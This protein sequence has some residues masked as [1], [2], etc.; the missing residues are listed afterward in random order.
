MPSE[1]SPPSGP[2]AADPEVELV[3]RAASGDGEAFTV[4]MRR[5]N[6]L[7]FRTARS[8]LQNDADAEDAVQEAYLRAWRALGR[9]RAES[10]LSTWL[11][12]IVVNEALGRRRSAGPLTTPLESVMDSPDPRIRVALADPPEDGP[13]ASV[14]R[15]EV[16]EQ[17]EAEID[18]L[19]EGFRTVFVLRAVEEMS[20]EEIAETL[21]IPAATVRTRYFRA[22][23][24]LRATLE[25]ATPAPLRSAYAF[26]GERC[27]RIVAR[28]LARARAEG[29]AVGSGTGVPEAP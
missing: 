3:A 9:Y 22:R 24:L 19:P 2:P 7:L 15:R 4:L 12:R 16:R 20:V 23:N 10:R 28:V 17:L 27:D 26:D 1:L 5:H 18:R 14:A 21:E 13:E 6:Q 8:I 29:L 25:S 11:V